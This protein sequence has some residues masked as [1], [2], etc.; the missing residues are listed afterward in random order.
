[1]ADLRTF[2]DARIVELESELARARA[3]AEAARWSNFDSYA[4][5]LPGIQRLET[6]LR[7]LRSVLTDFEATQR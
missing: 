4:N 2:I 1:M 3:G 6:E 5:H 7:I